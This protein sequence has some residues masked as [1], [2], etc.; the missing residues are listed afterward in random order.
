MVFATTDQHESGAS[1]LR[2]HPQRRTL[3]TMQEICEY[4]R[5]SG[6]TIRHYAKNFGFPARKVG[7]N[8]EADTDAIEQWK[9]RVGPE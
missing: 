4:M 3:R 6:N 2:S 5:V 8:W 7:G 9:E 1:A